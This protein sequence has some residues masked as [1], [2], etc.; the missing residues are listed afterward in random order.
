MP[1]GNS[2]IPDFMLNRLQENAARAAANPGSVEAAVA[3]AAVAGI[4]T[5]VACPEHAA[6]LAAAGALL[7]LLVEVPL[8]GEVPT[9][10]RDRAD[11]PP[12]GISARNLLEEPQRGTSA[13]YLA[14]V[15]L[16]GIL[17]GTSVIYLGEV[18]P[19]FTEQM[20]LAEV[21]PRF[22]K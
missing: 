19:Q 21:P 7:R 9:L 11:V 12:R 22:T 20:Y 4:N 10:A 18:P 14:E 8:L 5:I 15:P 16:R 3:A 6:K 1:S 13:M 17:Q 2:P